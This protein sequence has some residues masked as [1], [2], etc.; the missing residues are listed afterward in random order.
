MDPHEAAGRSRAAHAGAPR[1]R[2]PARTA[3][4]RWR[5]RCRVGFE[6]FHGVTLGAVEEGSH[7]AVDGFEGGRRDLLHLGE[8]A[9]E[10]DL[11]GALPDGDATDGLAHAEVGD[12]RAGERGG[13]LEVAFGARCHLAHDELL[14][15]GAAHGRRELLLKVVV[16]EDG[17]VGHLVHGRVPER[18]PARNDRDLVDRHLQAGCRGR[19]RVSRLVVRDEPLLV[20][21]ERAALALRAGDHAVDGLLEVGHADGG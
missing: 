9:A 3:H 18:P 17:A 6:S 11:T 7:L 4:R 5:R 8:V 16:G 14:D 10:E 13:G 21:R 15:G 20:G 12:H 19:D 2:S 1:T